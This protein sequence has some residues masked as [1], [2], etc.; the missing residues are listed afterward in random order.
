MNHA[1]S[2]PA[3][4]S[5][6]LTRH[7]PARMLMVGAA[8]LLP[9]MAQAQ[10]YPN[11]PIKVI[12]P[13]GPG[14]TCDLMMRL[15]SPRVSEKLGQPLVIENRAGSTGQLG[16]NLIKQSPPD[17]YT[18]GCGQ[19]G[20]LVIVPLAYEKVSYDAQKD[21]TPVALMGSN[22]LAL[23]VHP[24]TPFKTTEELIAYA[25]ANPGK[26]SFGSNGEGGFLHFATE[27]FR[28]QGNFSYMHVPYKSVGAAMTEVL[29]GQ[30]QATLTSYVAA[31]PLISAGK[32]RMLGVARSA[33]LPEYP[34][35]PTLSEAV[36]GFTSGGWFGV[37]APAGTPQEVVRLLNREINAALRLPEVRERM[38]TY[39]LD[40]HTEG[41]EFFAETMRSDL[42]KWGK[43][44]RDIGFKP[45]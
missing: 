29:G 44:V 4:P 40:V 10:A 39:G 20:N 32:V 9:V 2:A 6:W 22:F 8:L 14:D 45:M 30:I 35:V 33:R 15:V 16:L 5:H 37:I 18:L 17:G 25:R 24:G 27:M 26:V 1:R 42:A 12:I 21:F 41:P 11:K 7:L 13:A 3:T 43:L 38:K 19:G 23:V 28:I 36:P 31:Q 34:Q